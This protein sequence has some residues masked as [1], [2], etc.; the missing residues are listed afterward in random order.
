MTPDL[1]ALAEIIRSMPP[2]PVK[3]RMRD[4]RDLIA[5]LPRAE[6]E[7]DNGIPASMRGMAPRGVPVV[8]DKDVPPGVCEV[9]YSNGTTETI[10][11]AR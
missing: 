10:R 8:D 3:I 5:H 4:S 2:M 9:D 1:A 6:P 7:P 11:F